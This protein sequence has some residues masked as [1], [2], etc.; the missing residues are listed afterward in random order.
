MSLS[1]ILEGVEYSLED[2]SVAYHQGDDGFGMSPFHR[3]EERGPLQNGVTDR[4]F[5][6]DPRIVQLKLGLF[7][8][9]RAQ[10]YEK[11]NL[12]LAIF[13]PLDIPGILKSVE[14][15]LTLYLNAY[16]FGG[17]EYP[18]QD[19]SGYWLKTVVILKADDP[20]WYDPDGKSISFSLGGGGTGT[21][22]P[23]I[24]PTTVGASTIDVTTVIDYVGTAPSFP[25][26]IRINGPITD[27][28]ITNQASGDKLDFTGTTIAAGDYFDIDLRFDAKT[29]VDSSGVNKSDKLS[30]DSSITTWNIQQAPVA[31]NGQNPIRV[32]GSNV[33]A[34][35]KIDVSYFER[36]IGR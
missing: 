16:A 23:T 26:L 30:T 13:Q 11:R 14:N 20:T 8:N 7:A 34:D 33:N 29:V 15:G 12:L 31:P 1:W 21:P 18:S 19:K 25:D 2:G 17:M 24:V 22:V 27:C 3:L 9:N 5:R 32:T 35:T 10:F 36:Y 28:V 6:L 4:G